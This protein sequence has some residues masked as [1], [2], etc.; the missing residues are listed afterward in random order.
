MTLREALIDLLWGVG[1]A[2]LILLLIFF[3]GGG[4]HFIYVDF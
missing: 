4:S 3:S 2:L 1:A